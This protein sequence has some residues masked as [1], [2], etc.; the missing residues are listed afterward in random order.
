MTDL[1][2]NDMKHCLEFMG[3]PV[4]PELISDNTLGQ[5]F[6]MPD[7]DN[8]MTN[9]T[10]RVV[11]EEMDKMVWPAMGRTQDAV[12]K[13]AVT[14]HNAVIRYY[15]KDKIDEYNSVDRGESEAREA[16]RVVLRRRGYKD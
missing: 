12:C 5:F 11:C 13:S 10:S 6:L 9:I 3:K 14:T 8:P 1:I 7:I 2:K 4:P 15:N 16:I